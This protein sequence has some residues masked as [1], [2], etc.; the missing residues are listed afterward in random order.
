MERSL[1]DLVCRPCETEF[2][3]GLICWA[4]YASRASI[5]ACSSRSAWRACDMSIACFGT[6]T[7]E[8]VRR[9]AC[10]RWTAESA[11]KL[12]LEG[13]EAMDAKELA[14]EVAEDRLADDRADMDGEDSRDE[15]QEASEFDRDGQADAG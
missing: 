4:K 14:I 15:P 3:R 7:D 9:F 8:L 10:S 13:S 11:T 5:A 6:A 1:L 12:E 2:A